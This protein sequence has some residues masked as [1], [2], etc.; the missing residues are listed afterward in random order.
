V[1]GE[2]DDQPVLDDA[3]A[4]EKSRGGMAKLVFA[5]CAGLSRPVAGLSPQ[6]RSVLGVIALLTLANGAV[7][8]LWG[9]VK[10][11]L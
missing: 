4:G 11:L 5:V 3:P 2:V 1:K 7:A 9:V 10:N 8:T 6:G